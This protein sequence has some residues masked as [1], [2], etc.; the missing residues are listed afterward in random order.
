MLADHPLQDRRE[1][2]RAR[3]AWYARLRA[4]GQ[5]A[6]NG[7]IRNV[8]STGLYLETTPQFDVGSTLQLALHIPTDHGDHLVVLTATILRHLFLADMRGHGYGLQI[9]NMNAADRAIYDGKL[10]IL[11]RP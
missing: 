1:T 8:S 4:P 10:S 5:H 11:L 6:V 3:V 9:G 2:D 7:M